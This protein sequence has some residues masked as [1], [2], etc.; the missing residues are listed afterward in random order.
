MTDPDGE[1]EPQVLPPHAL[2]LDPGV[3][4][5]FD[6]GGGVVTVP[7]VGR[8]NSE[9]ATFTTGVTRFTQGT[10]LP[11]HFHNVEES[12][13]ILSGLAAAHIGDVHIEL[14]PGEATWVPA[15]VPH[16]FLNRGTEEMS[17]YWIYGGRYVTRTIVATGQTFEHLSPQDRGGTRSSV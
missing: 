17:I 1:G 15:G 8:W 14:E 16:R 6:R 3:I 13:L 10:A 2:H 9:L 12:V 11:M 7:Y 5:D 4:D